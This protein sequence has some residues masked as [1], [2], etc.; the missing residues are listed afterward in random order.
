MHATE[1][2][3]DVQALLDRIAHLEAENA[4]LKLDPFTGIMNAA[5]A[6]SLHAN[7]PAGKK[8]I[9]IDMCNIHAMNHKYLMAGV[10]ERWVN[11]FNHMR[12]TDILIKWGGDEFVII[13]NDGDVEQFL[14]R[15]DDTFHKFD[16]Y[17][18]YSVVTTSNSLNE[19]VARADAIAMK[20][21]LELEQ[22]GQKPGRDEPYRVLPSHIVYE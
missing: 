20:K 21:K 13:L 22:T 18:V 11:V 3:Y 19:S 9:F 17:A 16:C 15:L 4:K 1:Q 5:G 2:Q 7:I 14:D 12:L 10:N 8:L 6:L